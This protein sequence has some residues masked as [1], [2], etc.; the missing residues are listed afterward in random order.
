L[1]GSLRSGRRRRLRRWRNFLTDG[2]VISAGRT[3][4]PS[5]RNPR[6]GRCQSR[7]RTQSN[8]RIVAYGQHD[9]KDQRSQQQRAHGD[10]DQAKRP[11]LHGAA[12]F[13]CALPARS[14]KDRLSRG[15][16]ESLEGQLAR[17]STCRQNCIQA[18]RPS[19]RPRVRPIGAPHPPCDEVAADCNIEPTRAAKHR[20]KSGQFSLAAPH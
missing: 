3:R 14:R 12:F 5:T 7:Q 6:C 17:S 11:G 20:P 2:L 19:L 1:G 8:R 9:H 16:P 18:Q 4:S 13:L 15:S 10:R